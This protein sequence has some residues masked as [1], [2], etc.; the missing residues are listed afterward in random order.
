MTCEYQKQ[1]EN[2]QRCIYTKPCEHQLELDGINYCG[3]EMDMATEVEMVSRR[4]E[5]IIENEKNM[6]GL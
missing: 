1:F 5:Q 4:L 2:K 6:C 3:K